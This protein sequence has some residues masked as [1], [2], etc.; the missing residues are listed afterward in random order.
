[1]VDQFTETTR[2]SWGSRLGGSCGGIFM[3][4]MF[5]LA[6]F[7]VLFWNEGRV[8]LSKIAQNAQPI[9][10]TQ[11]AES[12]TFVAARGALETQETIGEE[13]AFVPKNYIALQQRSEIYAWVEKTESRSETKLGGSEETETTYT[14]TKQWVTLPADSSTFRIPEGHQNPGGKLFENKTIKTQ[15]ATLGTYT[16]D[17]SNLQLGGYEGVAISH[18]TMNLEPGMVIEGKY[19]FVGTGS[20][21]KPEI[22]D[23]RI[24]YEAVPSGK[25]VTVFASVDNGSLLPFVD[26]KGNTLY[27]AMT[28]PF[29]QAVEQMHGEYK[30]SLWL[31]RL[32][33]LLLMWIGLGS[34]LAPLSVFL[35]VLP[36]AG[37]ISRSLVSIVTFIISLVLSAITIAISMIFHNIWALLIVAALGIAGIVWYIKNKGEKMVKK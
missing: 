4:V 8:D 18:D 19:V 22:G 21:Q 35:D 15:S 11:Q 5:F 26:K 2:R 16:L 23:E 7:F 37:K 25:T 10:A 29:E 28:A 1:M 9:E 6:S 36:I 13:F 33:G 30:F 32:L 14:Y 12:G 27:R 34:I 24:W 17:P 31:L 3:G 20:L